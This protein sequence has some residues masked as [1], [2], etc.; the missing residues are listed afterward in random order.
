MKTRTRKPKRQLEERL[1][2]IQAAILEEEGHLMQEE[3]AD[4]RQSALAIKRE[5]ELLYYQFN[6]LQQR[7]AARLRPFLLLL[8]C[9]PHV[10][11]CLP[12]GTGQVEVGTGG[13]LGLLLQGCTP[14]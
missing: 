13:L 6:L 11:P 14:Y 8:A 4:Q 1:E 5:L 10:C 12:V 7:H 2:E 3:L 9:L